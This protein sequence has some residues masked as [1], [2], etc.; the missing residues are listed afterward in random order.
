MPVIWQKIK[1]SGRVSQY[2]ILH[3]YRA[4]Q[5]NYYGIVGL[6]LDRAA[7]G[8]DFR[9]HFESHKASDGPV[10]LTRQLPFH[11]ISYQIHYSVISLSFDVM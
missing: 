6:V 8:T 3:S 2:R 11:S 10:V 4:R 7:V 5:N 9:S 1:T